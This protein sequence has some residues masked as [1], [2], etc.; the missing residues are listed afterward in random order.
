LHIN[1]FLIATLV[2]GL[3]APQILADLRELPYK[4][5]YETPE[6]SFNFQPIYPLVIGEEARLNLRSALAVEEVTIYLPDGS[7]VE[8]EKKIDVWS[9]KFKVSKNFKEGWQPLYIYLKHRVPLHYKTLA[10]QMLELL[11]LPTETRY[12]T[13]LLA[14]RIWI[15]AFKPPPI[16]PLPAPP[17]ALRPKEVSPEA[18]ALEVYPTAEAVSPEAAG[19]IIKGTRLFS[20]SSKS[21]EGTKE[22][23][24]PGVNREESLRINVSGKAQE[25]DIDANFFSTST[26]GT[27]QVASQEQ[28]ISIKLSHAST[29]AYFGDFTADLTDTE[30]S[31]LN[32]VLSGIKLSGNYPAWGFKAIASNPQGQSQFFKAYG[33]GTQGPYNL[34]SSPVVIDSERVYVDGIWQKR[35]DDYLVDYNAGTITFKTHTIIKT[36]IIEVYYDYRQTL[37]QHSTYAL[38][39]YSQINPNLKM[40]ASWIDDSDSLKDA[41][42]IFLNQTS[43]TIEPQ[44]HYIIGVDGSFKGSDLL[45]AQGEVAYSEKKTNILSADS[46]KDIGKA[47]KLETISK[48][49]PFE[50]QTKFKRIGPQFEPAAEA[51]PKQDLLEYSGLLNFN[52]NN[53]FLASANYGSEKYAQGGTSFKNIYRNAKAKLAPPKL[54]ALEYRLDELE[55]SNDPVP[56]YT[57]IDRLTTKNSYEL[58][59]TLGHLNLSAQAINEKRLNRT[60][61]LEA[62]IYKTENFGLSTVGLEIITLAANL[63]LK[64]T[65]LPSGLTPFTRTYNLNLSATPR[66]EY[67]ASVSLNYID[68]SQ[69][70]VTNVTDLVFRADPSEKVKTDGKYTISSVKETFSSSQEG[71][72][73]NVGSFR[74]ELRPTPPLRLRYYYKPNYTL[75]ARTQNISYNNETQQYEI[76]WLFLSSAMLGATL[77]TNKGFIVDKTDYPNY[78]R[79]DQTLDS[80]STLYTLKAAPLRFL[81]TEFNY[82]IDDSTGN[83]LQIPATLESYARSNTSA[84]EFN[85]TVKTSLSER[86]A[87]DSSYSNKISRQGSEEIWDDVQNTITQTESIKGIWNLSDFWTFSVSY[88]YS[89]SRNFLAITNRDTYTLSPGAGFIYRFGDTF[90][91]DGDYTY[92]K[93]FAGAST[94]KHTYSL[95]AK[96]DVSEYLHVSLRGDREVSLLPD[97]KT[98]DFSGNVEI[99]L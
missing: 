66:K 86:F 44:S 16:T 29:E 8:L 11:R 12:K 46:P 73:K 6:F 49:G 5:K 40:G 53:V 17:V 31:K 64:D 25:T 43:G 56:P 69:D 65:E 35:G 82:I 19:L 99:N 80:R 21:I 71:V 1:K 13:E 91:V 7:K 85:A 60:P 72:I 89:Q 36:S 61:S 62:T 93:S 83:K 48:T 95:R 76:N 3:L 15:R 27:T 58:T 68:D 4:E 50:L 70:G 45:S 67:L 79:L 30:F 41:E 28:K 98:A 20:F 81:S 51:L 77:N 78:R 94:E 59:H 34:G 92:S 2:A 54:P 22:G 26:I 9:G 23:Y 88:A 96:Y 97:Y 42:D 37:Y 74:L 39:T 38:R 47:A 55:E 63:E 14:K 24:L 10:D 84:Q 57:E 52:P 87:I 33:D 75:V 18:F 90:R 32:K